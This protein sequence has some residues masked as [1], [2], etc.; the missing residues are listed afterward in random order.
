MLSILIFAV[1]LA[2][3][4]YLY[5]VFIVPLKKERDDYD[6][7]DNDW[8]YGDDWRQGSPDVS[9]SDDTIEYVTI[10]RGDSGRG[11]DDTVMIDLI[12]YLGARGIRAIYDS[13]SIGLEPAAIKT[14]VLKVEAGKE[15]EAQKYLE[16]KFRVQRS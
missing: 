3:L 5:I 10:L 15:D 11:Y 4:Y 16:E 14:Y 7:S 6:K 12:G 8:E 13:F 2:T 1:V 9:A